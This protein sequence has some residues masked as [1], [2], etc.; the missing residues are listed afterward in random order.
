MNFLISIAATFAIILGLITNS[1]LGLAFSAFI[2]LIYLVQVASELVDLRAQLQAFIQGKLTSR[3]IASPLI[4]ALKFRIGGQGAESYDS[5]RAIS[6]TDTSARRMI[7]DDQSYFADLGQRL[8]ARFGHHIAALV[9]NADEVWVD[10]VD[11]EL[12]KRKLQH[13]YFNRKQLTNGET[14][15][16]FLRESGV[17]SA[18]SDDFVPFSV[19]SFI[20]LPLNFREVALW[21]GYSA[22]RP[23]LSSEIVAVR[24]FSSELA[25]E[26]ETRSTLAEIRGGDR[27]RSEFLTQISHDLRSPL[28]NVRAILGLM[29]N[30]VNS[31]E[32]EE[33]I[34]MALRNC[35][36]ASDLAED[37]LDFS[38]HKAGKLQA[39]PGIFDLVELVTECF[40]NYK[41]GARLKGFDYR[42]SFPSESCHAYADR[43][44]IKRVLNNIIGNAI[45]FTAKGL[46]EVAV[47]RSAHGRC[48]IS[49]RDTGS[50]MSQS[51]LQLLFS[52]FVTFGRN[53]SVGES[54]AGIGL[55]ISRILLD[56]NAG[57][58]KVGS[59]ERHGSVFS[60]EL[61]L[62]ESTQS[63]A[64]FSTRLA[65][66]IRVL[67]IDDDEDCSSSLARSLTLQGFEVLTALNPRQAI[68]ILNYQPPEIVLT[69]EQ[70]PHGGAAVVIKFI[71][72]RKL[73][74]NLAYISGS[75]VTAASKHR[76]FMKP[77]D[78][79][80]IA[81]WIRSNV[82]EMR[83][84]EFN[85]KVA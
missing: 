83:N 2:V 66:R 35:D 76:A 82:G 14:E 31:F 58:I 15:V 62:A 37:V 10:G 56:L 63:R 26:L 29:R 72:S 17:E 24:K 41:I 43:K 18:L 73:P 47:A 85:E 19:R 27:G 70:M 39:V 9:F 42:L 11:S 12:F 33:L 64:E 79:S 51:E 30:E 50:G 60:I 84:S 81:D 57:S 13:W 16:A 49:I 28:N 1:S 65:D 59:R 67:V 78:P 53:G 71:E 7:L 8:K 38:K 25:I 21:L 32:Q 74:I 75:P 3:Q 52:P 77:L 36:H 69:D 34:T 68:N 48:Q 22:D 20:C 40:E 61:P 4:Q 54:G 45:K 46:V 6:S 23:P 44:Q 80:E 55:A 5:Q